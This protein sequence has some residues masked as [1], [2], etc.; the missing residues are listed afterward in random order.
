MNRHTEDLLRKIGLQLDHGVFPIVK[1]GGIVLPSESAILSKTL[2]KESY[3]ARERRRASPAP[4]P[5]NTLDA[6]WTP[7]RI[8]AISWRTESCWCP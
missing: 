2:G 6:I 1:N 4:L 5:A 3:H 8:M 7:S